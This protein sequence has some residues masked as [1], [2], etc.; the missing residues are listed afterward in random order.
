MLQVLPQAAAPQLPAPLRPNPPPQ[1]MGISP[2]GGT[3]ALQEVRRCFDAVGELL[4]D[5]R[6]YLTG[7]AFTAAD[8]S[9][10]SLAA[11]AV[12]QPYGSAPGLGGDTP[13]AMRAEIEELRAHPAGRFALRLWAEER[14]VVL[15]A[16]AGS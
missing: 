4:A 14:G 15:Q 2:Q 7:D 9:F 6:R 13:A 8:L 3:E 5:G 1:G 16:A 10:A 12:G 11:P